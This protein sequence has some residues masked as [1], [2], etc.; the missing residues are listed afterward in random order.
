M[1]LTSAEWKVMECLW[2]Q[3]PQ[4]VVQLAAAL[5]TRV[6]WAKS[7]STTTVTRMAAKGL[8]AVEEG[9]KARLYTPAV[10]RED[11]VRE[12]TTRF[13]DRVYH[14][15]VSLLLNTMVQDGGLSRDELDAL[16]A[17][18]DRAEQEERRK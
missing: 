2:E 8:L 6:G 18:L 16:H 9:G 12:Q 17:I 5:H 4:T 1:T 7:T 13:L 11:A 14:G 10:R 3:A 15:S